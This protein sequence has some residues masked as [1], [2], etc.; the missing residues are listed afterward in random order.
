MK[1]IITRCRLFTILMASLKVI[2]NSLRILAWQFNLLLHACGGG[3]AQSKSSYGYKKQYK[4]K[5]KFSNRNDSFYTSKKIDSLIAEYFCWWIPQPAMNAFYGETKLP[6]PYLLKFS[7][8]H[9][10]DQT[11]LVAIRINTNLHMLLHFEYFLPCIYIKEQKVFLRQA[12][13]AN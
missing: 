2:V 8:L 6:P 13:A 1:E 12:F 5:V 10:Y 4:S 7:T 3:A 9:W 11:K